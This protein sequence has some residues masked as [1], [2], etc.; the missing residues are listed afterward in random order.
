MLGKRFLT[1]MVLVT[2][3]TLQEVAVKVLFGFYHSGDSITCFSSRLGIVKGW[4]LSGKVITY[5]V[6]G[7]IEKMKGEVMGSG[8]PG[9]VCRVLL[10]ALFGIVLCGLSGLSLLKAELVPEFAPIREAPANSGMA[11][12]A[13]IQ[14]TGRQSYNPGQTFTEPVTGMEFVWVPGGGCFQMG[15]NDGDYDEKPVHK[16]CV[17]GFWLGKYEVTQ[18]QWQ[19]I[20]GNNPS[21][22]PKGWFKKGDNYPVEMVSWNDCQ[23]F[24]KKL[25]AQSTRKFRLPTEAE[26][27]YAARSG[28]RD[29]TYAGGNDVDR[30]SWY[31]GNS[32]GSTHHVGGKAPNGLGFYDMSGNVREWCADWYSSDY[33]ED[34]PKRN[35][36]GPASGSNRVILGGSWGNGSWRVRSVDR[37]WYGLADRV[38]YLGFRLVSP[39]RH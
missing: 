38:N 33:Y 8:W 10:M 25:N 26:W 19:K 17:D 14:E 20:M 27:E 29:E 34:S 11:R 3:K 36:T 9:V 1:R 28:G 15:S 23:E 30:V 32:G 18:G 37:G 31:D 2:V 21:K 35:P 39:G 12:E 24:I 6:P 13:A 16:V 4:L 7:I 22:F 5:T